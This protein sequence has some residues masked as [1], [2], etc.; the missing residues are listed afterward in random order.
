MIEYYIP[1]NIIVGYKKEKDENNSRLAYITYKDELGKL[2]FE[3]S[4]NNWRNVNVQEEYY[5]NDIINSLMVVD[6]AGGYK[7]GWNYRQEYIRLLDNRGFM[8]DITTD[9][10]LWLLDYSMCDYGVLK[11]EF[12]LAWISN[13]LYLIPV[14]SNEYKI[15]KKYSVHR[16]NKR[17]KKTSEMTP[18]KYYRLKNYSEAKDHDW[19]NQITDFL[20]IGSLPTIQSDMSV[21]S[22]LTFLSLNKDGFFFTGIKGVE[23][24]TSNKIEDISEYI[25]QF[26]YSPYSPRFWKEHRFN[27]T[28]I[29]SDKEIKRYDWKL[30]PFNTYINVDGTLWS[31][32]FDDKDCYNDK[33]YYSSRYEFDYKKSTSNESL[34]TFIEFGNIKGIFEFPLRI[35]GRYSSETSTHK[36][37]QDLLSNKE[38]VFRRHIKNKFNTDENWKSYLV[39]EKS[40]ESS[41]FRNQ[42]SFDCI[43]DG[44]KYPI[45]Q[46]LLDG[47][48]FGYAGE[49]SVNTKYSFPTKIY[50]ELV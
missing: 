7:S 28:L 48:L 36:F 40:H 33:C 19:K 15:A 1:D 9:N 45:S 50:D 10:F 17:I 39:F 21:K 3:T 43:V 42:K 31:Y 4:W 16:Q 20:F 47:F 32:K 41:L 35:R 8:F 5:S 29:P 44:Y 22:R 23:F 34:N 27:M 25:K 6:T 24:E 38:Y 14:K 30:H 49:F 13:N 18:G 26:E 11:G 12:S 37:N 46:F 2:K